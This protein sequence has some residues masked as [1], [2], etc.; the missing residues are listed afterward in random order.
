MYGGPY[1]STDG[2]FRKTRC[3]FCRQPFRK[4]DNCTLYEGRQKR[5]TGENGDSRDFFTLP[6]TVKGISEDKRNDW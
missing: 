6:V 3:I 1:P 5:V 2:V 4:E